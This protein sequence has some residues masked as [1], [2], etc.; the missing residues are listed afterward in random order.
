MNVNDI[1]RKLEKKFGDRVSARFE[2]GSIILT[3]ELDEWSDVVEAG[4][5]A[6]LNDSCGQ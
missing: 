5:H 3:G 2:D 6:V 4:M 1:N